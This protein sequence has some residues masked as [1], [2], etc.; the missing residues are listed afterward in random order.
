MGNP[1]A[2]LSNT[3]TARNWSAD[4]GEGSIRDDATAAKRGFRGGTVV[5]PIAPPSLVVEVL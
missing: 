5:G 2:A 4:A 1:D 3:W